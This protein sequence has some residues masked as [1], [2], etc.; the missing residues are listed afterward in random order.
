LFI[1]FQ[2]SH[3]F[4]VN[5]S[6]QASAPGREKI[7]SISGLSNGETFLYSSIHFESFVLAPLKACRVVYRDDVSSTMSPSVITP[8]SGVWIEP[9]PTT[10]KISSAIGVQ[11][12]STRKYMPFVS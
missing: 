1:P 10:E 6:T 11:E 8:V 4:P 7:S 5:C 3:S 12:N 9:S 2:P